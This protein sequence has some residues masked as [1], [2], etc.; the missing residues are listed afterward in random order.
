MITFLDWLMEAIYSGDATIST[1]GMVI[2]TLEGDH[3]AQSGDWI[4]QGV[5]GELYPCK[6]DIFEM[7]Y[8]IVEDEDE[9]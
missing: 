8:E 3:L 5:K 2:I 9:K 7:T 4:I 6:P 1:K